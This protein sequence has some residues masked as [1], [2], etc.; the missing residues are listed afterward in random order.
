MTYSLP[1]L[2]DPTWASRRRY[3]IISKAQSFKASINLVLTILVWIVVVLIPASL[4]PDDN[5]SV[6]LTVNIAMI[7]WIGT[8]IVSTFFERDPRNIPIKGRYL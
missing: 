2:P 6:I 4:I 5:K 8:L 3:E 7:M 1:E